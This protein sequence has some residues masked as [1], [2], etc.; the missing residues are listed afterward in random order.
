M[1]YLE[2]ESKCITYDFTMIASPCTHILYSG[3]LVPRLFCVGGE[4]RARYTLSAHAPNIITIH[5]DVT[6]VTQNINN[7]YCHNV[8][9]TRHG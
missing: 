5:T 3:S 6:C 4:K 1:A 2:N 7:N 9:S 8:I